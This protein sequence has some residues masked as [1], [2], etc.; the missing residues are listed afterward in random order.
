MVKK[1]FTKG[2]L[3]SIEDA[4]MKKSEVLA[5]AEKWAKTEA[6]LWTPPFHA[7]YHSDESPYWSVRS[8]AHGKGGTIMIIDDKLGE[9][10]EHHILGR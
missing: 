8:N 4:V 7:D 9:V 3:L 10:I 1:K 6:V 5:L 2:D